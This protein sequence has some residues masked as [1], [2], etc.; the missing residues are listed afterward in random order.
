MTGQG[1]S[2]AALGHDPV[3]GQ[4]ASYIMRAN[5]GWRRPIQ[6]WL[7]V[8]IL[9]PASENP[10][11]VE[12]VIIDAPNMCMDISCCHVTSCGLPRLLSA[13]LSN[14]S[15]LSTKWWGA[16]WCR[17]RFTLPPRSKLLLFIGFGPLMQG[18]I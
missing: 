11:P 2:K 18:N 5:I 4:I 1:A 9:W 17:E 7:L 10:S 8:S 13:P 6:S 14:I 15:P 16:A 3:P 12:M